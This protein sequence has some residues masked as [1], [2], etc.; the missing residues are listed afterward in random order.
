MVDGEQV[1]VGK[2][3]VENP[4]EMGKKGKVLVRQESKKV[5]NIQTQ[6]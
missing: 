3:V 6:A 1:T 5:S 4:M 2:E